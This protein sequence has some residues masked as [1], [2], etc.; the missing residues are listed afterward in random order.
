MMNTETEAYWQAYLSA[1]PVDLPRPL[2]YLADHC[3]SSP[4]EAVELAT[5]VLAGTKTATAGLLWTYPQVDG[6]MLQPGDFTVVTDLCD[7]PLGVIETTHIEVRP[8]RLVDAEHA[9]LEGEGDRTLRFWREV[10]WRIFASECAELGREA[11]EDMPV[12]CE[13]FRLVYPPV[14]A[15]N[16]P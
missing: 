6:R 3:G 7:R 12:V 10:H 16:R 9:Y 8:F 2:S 4:E 11:S 13:R 15:G 14:V 1:L 5:L